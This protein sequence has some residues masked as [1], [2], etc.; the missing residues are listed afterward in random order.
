M[1]LFVRVAEMLY[2]SHFKLRLAVEAPDYLIVW[3]HKYAE[4]GRVIYSKK[5]IKIRDYASNEYNTQ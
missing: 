5:F 1:V 2:Y 3:Q 4:Q